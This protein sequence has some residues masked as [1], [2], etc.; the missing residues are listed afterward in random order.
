VSPIQIKGL[1]LGFDNL[2]HR[3]PNIYDDILAGGTF[4]IT[5]REHAGKILERCV[6]RASP[7]VLQISFA[8]MYLQKSLKNTYPTVCHLDFTILLTWQKERKD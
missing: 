4:K 8:F 7:T 1:S 6:V 2:N 3:E 5:N